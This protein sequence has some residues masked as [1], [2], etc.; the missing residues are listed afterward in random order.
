[1]IPSLPRE[2]TRYALWYSVIPIPWTL[3]FPNEKRLAVMFS[4]FLELP[5]FSNGLKIR[6]TVTIFPS[7]GIRAQFDLRES[8]SL[9]ID[10]N[11]T[12]TFSNIRAFVQVSQI[13]DS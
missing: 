10:L 13:T 11:V 6:T 1:M 7:L 9:L 2:I 3:A 4:L 12:M 8:H 5:D